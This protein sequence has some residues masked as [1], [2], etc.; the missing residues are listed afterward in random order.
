MTT[1]S[2]RGIKFSGMHLPSSRI[3]MNRIGRA[4]VDL[5]G[6]EPGTASLL[7]LIGNVF[8]VNMIETVAETHVLAEKSG[9]SVSNLQKAIAVL[10]GGPY[11]IYSD[12]MASGDYYKNEVCQLAPRSLRNTRGVLFLFEPALTYAIFQSPSWPLVTRIG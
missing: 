1:P 8:I 11:K 7:K 9:L 12:R 2:E 5:G 4:V 6:Q 3:A 10:F